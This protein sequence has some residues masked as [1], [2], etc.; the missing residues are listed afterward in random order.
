LIFGVLST[1][2]SCSQE[3]EKRP[4]TL[5]DS[6]EYLS[7]RNYDFTCRHCPASAETVPGKQNL[8]EPLFTSTLGRWFFSILAATDYVCH[9]AGSSNAFMQG[10]AHKVAFMCQPSGFEKR[11]GDVLKLLKPLYGLKQEPHVWNQT[12]YIFFVCIGSVASQSD[13]SVF[14]LCEP[15]AGPRFPSVSSRVCI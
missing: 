8:P 15:S 4:N 6:L 1:V 13:G 2:I 12:F 9:M 14:T 5:Q 3:N 7:S 11:T 10:T